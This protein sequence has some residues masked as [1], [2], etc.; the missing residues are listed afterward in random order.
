MKKIFLFSTF[1]LY[2]TF[3]QAQSVNNKWVLG[4]GVGA[5]GIID[6]M[7]TGLLPEIYFSRYLNSRF[8]LMVKEK[9]YFNDFRIKNDLV[10]T[11]TFINIR[12]KLSGYL[13]YFYV[14]PGY[15][16]QKNYNTVNL[17]FGFGSKIKITPTSVLYFDAGYIKGKK[18]AEA[19]YP[20]NANLW[21]ATVGIEFNFGKAKE[22]KI[23]REAV[24]KDLYIKSPVE[25]AVVD[26]DGD[27]VPDSLD[28]CPTEPG[29]I[30]LKGCPDSDKDGVADKD[31]RCPNTPEGVKV[32]IQGCPI[33]LN[34]KQEHLTSV[35]IKPDNKD[36][37]IVKELIKKDISSDQVVIQNIKVAAA[38]FV[39]NES[40]LT[41]YSKAKMDQLIEI[42][43]SNP[44]YRIN[45]I[46]Y[47][48][49]QGSDD[50]NIKLSQKRIETVINYLISRGIAKDR[51]ISQK[52]FGKANPLASNDTEE[53]RQKNRRVEFEIFKM[54]KITEK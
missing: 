52:A 43:N 22:S 9:I 51:I 40:Y 33:D 1:I 32:D 18:S 34:E 38:H 25:V 41:D 49:S 2:L 30:T 31:D 48:D 26:T 46:G 17:N 47:A 37:Q 42:L 6:E 36:V 23:N 28:N 7:S 16:F 4:L 14:G 27:G 44:E 8:D 24:K 20:I 53:G 45:A 29:L 50:Y 5:F 19:G 11:N 10:P 54:K 21:N 35:L 3:S 39:S 13:P 12:F 15:W